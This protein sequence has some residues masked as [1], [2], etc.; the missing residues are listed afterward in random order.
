MLKNVIIVCVNP[1]DF[2][3]IIVFQLFIASI[4]IISS[5]LISTRSQ[6]Q[7]I[8][9]VG[10]AFC[11]KDIKPTNPNILTIRNILF[12]FVKILLLYRYQ[13]LAFSIHYTL[14]FKILN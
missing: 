3:Q 9:T 14:I 13:Y 4:P 8:Y 6:R 11:T 10:F 5:G 2:I 12:G 1:I 7:T